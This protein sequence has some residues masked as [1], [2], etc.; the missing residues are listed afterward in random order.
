MKTEKIIL[1]LILLVATITGGIL[2]FFA[3]QNNRY[4]TFGHNN[5]FIWDNWKEEPAF[6]GD[7]NSRAR[8]HFDDMYGA[9]ELYKNM[10]KRKERQ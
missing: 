7:E 9:K 2:G 1:Y 8:Y 4:T 10:N 3:L 6:V 5:M